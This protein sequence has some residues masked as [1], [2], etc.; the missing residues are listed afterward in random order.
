MFL[1]D[2]VSGIYNDATRSG[3]Y[4]LYVTIT[5]NNSKEVQK[6]FGGRCKVLLNMIVLS[7][8]EQYCVKCTVLKAQIANNNR[9]CGLY[10]KNIDLLMWKKL[11]QDQYKLEKTT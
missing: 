8:A 9:N 1:C 7:S 6:Y 4:R 11:I 2:A 3:L 5:R 10:E